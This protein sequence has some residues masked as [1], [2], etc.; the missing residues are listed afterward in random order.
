MQIIEEEGAK[1]SFILQPTKTKAFWPTQN[2]TLLK[3]LTDQFD[4]DV[5]PTHTGI[6]TLG[7]PLGSESFVRDFILAKFNDI[8]NSIKLAITINDGRAAQNIH[9]AT[10]SACRMTHLLRLVP[11]S[12]ASHLWKDFD[13]RQS[14]WLETMCDV[15]RSTAARAQAR[16]PRALAGLGVYSAADIAPCA[17]IGS[18]VDS[19][20]IRADGRPHSPRATDIFEMIAPAINSLQPSLA[21][22]AQSVLPPRDPHLLAELPAS[23]QKVLSQAVFHRRFREA[24]RGDDYKA[25]F[26]SEKHTGDPI[27]ESDWDILATRRR[28]LAIRMPGANAFLGAR[29]TDEPF[30]S[31]ELWSTILRIYQGCCVYED[32]TAQ[33]PARCGHCGFDVLE[34]RGTHAMNVCP[35]GWGR[36]AR[37]DRLATLF[38][39]WLVSPAVLSFQGKYFRGEAKGLLFGTASRPAD[40]LI[41][42]PVPRQER[43]Q[44]I[45]LRST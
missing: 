33:S 45:Q 1:I 40:A 13:N 35:N 18:I 5:R 32:S 8:D 31:K 36:V 3:P 41:F 10:A 9:R 12:E 14:T 4:L 21:A 34:K 22:T 25:R 44:I 7:V 6:K 42:P 38:L 19:A 27:C 37:H 43:G 2:K 17:Y 30:C 24:S 29:P 15:P 11:P 20:K 28:L 26:D 16:L 23:T 39:R